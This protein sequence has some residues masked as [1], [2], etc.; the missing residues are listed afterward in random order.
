MSTQA[1][2]AAA[3]GT[4]ILGGGGA[5]IAYAA[6]AFNGEIKYKNFDDYVSRSG[7]YEYIGKLGGETEDGSIKKK[8]EVFLKNSDSSKKTA[9]KD[10][11][12]KNIKGINESDEANNPKPTDDEIDRTISGSDNTNE[13][14]KTSKFVHNWC[15][16]NKDLKPTQ[17]EGQIDFKETEIT[18]HDNWDRFKEL[19]LTEVVRTNNV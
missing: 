8:V 19:C 13:L 12:K 7:K 3:A 11:L 17:K 15:K 14:E 6:G 2:G 4:A 16:K 1:I 18:S 10:K 5:T 9:Y